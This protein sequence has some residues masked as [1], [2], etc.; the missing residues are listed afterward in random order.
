[1]NNDKEIDDAVL[2]RV[3]LFHTDATLCGVSAIAQKTNAPSLLRTEAI[4]YYKNPGLTNAD[5]PP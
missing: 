5:L 4:C 1:M 3:R 2:E